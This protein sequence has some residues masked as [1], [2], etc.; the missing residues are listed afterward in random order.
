MSLPAEPEVNWDGALPR[1]SSSAGYIA[2]AEEYYCVKSRSELMFEK[3]SVRHGL[4]MRATP[5]AG[6]QTDTHR[7]THT[8]RQTDRHTNTHRQTHT[9]TH[10]QTDTHT[11]T[12]TQTHTFRHTHQK[13]NR[14]KLMKK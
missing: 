12:D 6:S 3:Q 1:R 5:S 14:N 4:T 8:D 2:M 13:K 9:D 7:Q 10:R 11:Q